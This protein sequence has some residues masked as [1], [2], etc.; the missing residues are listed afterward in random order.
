MGRHRDARCR[1]GTS[2]TSLRARHP[3]GDRAPTLR[4]HRLGVLLA[5][6][7]FGCVKSYSTAI[8]DGRRLPPSE[9]Q[10]SDRSE[11]PFV[12]RG[13]DSAL[14]AVVAKW[15]DVNGRCA[16]VR[17]EMLAEVNGLARRDK[18]LGG[19]FVALGTALALATG[20]Y[21]FAA[22]TPDS[23]IA[24]VLALGAASTT[25]PVFL[26]VGG[27]ERERL[28][29]EKLQ[30][31]DSQRTLV[32]QAWSNFAE[33]ERELRLSDRRLA[34]AEEALTSALNKSPTCAALCSADQEACSPSPELCSP[35]P[36]TC[37][38]TPESCLRTFEACSRV[39]EA[40]YHRAEEA[41]NRTREPC[42]RAVQERDAARREQAAFL[43]RH[44]TAT[45]AF[46]D[47]VA[48]LQ[49]VCR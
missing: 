22:D 8:S 40:C 48:K 3:L 36:E 18:V 35:S 31:I 25:A 37:R 30:A 49:E 16:I 38:R 17:E 2:G 9:A 29:R 11:L 15:H 44:D 34:S 4:A 43:Q 23:K 7:M 12:E 10:A 13:E 33:V 27:S 41:C 26:F 42:N 19:S 1:S 32:N 21:S 47:A 6:G 46:V 20:I 45:D 5:L 14:A 28:V 39:R 24:G